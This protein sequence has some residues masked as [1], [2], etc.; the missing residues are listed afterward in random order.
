MNTYLIQ[1]PKLI[2]V[3]YIH[4]LHIPLQDTDSITEPQ[5]NNIVTKA[6]FFIKAGA[7]KTAVTQLLPTVYDIALSIIWIV[8]N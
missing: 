7:N 6:L 2:M 4:V 1:K 5:C 3:H 8:L